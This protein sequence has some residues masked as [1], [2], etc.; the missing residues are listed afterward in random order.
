M[1]RPV[2]QHGA[3]DPES[4]Q[5]DL[6]ELLLTAQRPPGTAFP[7]GADDAA[8]AELHG[9]L[10]IPLPP[11]LVVWLRVCKGDI[12]GPG[13]VFGARPDDPSIDIAAVLNQFP[14]W[15]ARGWIPV[16]GDG[17]GDYYVLL[18]EGDNA[19]HVGFVDQADLDAI[20]MV[21]ATDLARFVGFLLR[22]DRDERGWPF[23]RATVLAADPAMAQ[24]AADLQSSSPGSRSGSVIASS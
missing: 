1:T 15:K 9:R 12:V 19:G 5:S 3:V 21:V 11:A 6:V 24:V 7:G 17:C 18:T 2:E 8:L 14:T 16:A 23:D 22:R 20:E 10:G 4:E 13:G